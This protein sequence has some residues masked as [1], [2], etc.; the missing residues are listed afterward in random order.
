VSVPASAG[1]DGGL[2]WTNASVRAFAAG[3]DPLE[4]VVSTSRQVM[5]AAADN[6][7]KGPPFDPFALAEML[8]LALRARADVA[9]AR[10]TADTV[11]VRSTPHAPLSGFVPAGVPLVVEYNPTRPHGRMRY[12]VAHE[13]AHA[14]FPDVAEAARHRTGGGA[15]PQYGGDDSWQLELLCNVAAAE[16]LMPAQAVAGIS[17]VDPDIDFIMAQ[18]QRFDVST[19]ALLRRLAS[20]T[21]RPLAVLAASRLADRADSAFRIEYVVPSAAFS[22]DAHRGEQVDADSVLGA[23]AAVGQTARGSLMIGG[24]ALRVQAV[25]VPP[26]PGRVLPRVLVIAEP[27]E[28]PVTSSA[29][30]RYVSGDVAW[31]SAS[32]PVVIGHVTNSTARAWGR[33]G[34]AAALSRRFPHAATAYY[35]W[36]VADAANLRPG[37]VHFTQ[38]SPDPPV[39][40]ASMVAQIG[41]GQ[42]TPDRI[43]YT[44]LA[45]ALTTVGDWA[46]EH[47]AEVHLPRIG[48]GQGG[49]RWDLIEAEIDEALVR[50]NLTVVIYTP[51]SA[52]RPA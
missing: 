46:L 44:A 26:Y 51:S 52:W 29:G 42:G 4:K 47:E 21:T 13:V 35:Y 18:R 2:E 12:N 14:F 3:D 20:A 10:V 33:R 6:G 19:E 45:Q 25:G 28:A 48:A 1:P 7:L 23:C 41:Y 15:L 11:G 9:D 37:M 38:A 31:P 40:V 16:F 27:A 50:R 5:A 17:D 49:G 34:V 39:W 30:L 22:P 24:T 36:A 43:A 32:V 8:G